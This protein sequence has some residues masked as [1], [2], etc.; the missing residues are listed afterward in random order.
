MPVFASDPVGQR[1]HMI[2]DAEL[3]QTVFEYL[4][5]CVHSRASDSSPV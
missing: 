2:L 3:V 4:R 5:F 1:N